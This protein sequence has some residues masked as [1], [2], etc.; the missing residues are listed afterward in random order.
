M[1]L[2]IDYDRKILLG[3]L[4]LSGDL[5]AHNGNRIKSLT[6]AYRN[7]GYAPTSSNAYD[8]A[9]WKYGVIAFMVKFE[10]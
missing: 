1:K 3:P 4:Y 6:C 8:A 9:I 2:K 10:S 7:Y 5:V